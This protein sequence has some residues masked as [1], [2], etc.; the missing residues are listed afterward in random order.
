MMYDAST[1]P[2]DHDLLNQDEYYSMQ[3]KCE[4]VG[5]PSTKLLNCISPMSGMTQK[6]PIFLNN[7][8]NSVGLDQ[9]SP[10]TMHNSIPILS[11]MNIED[12]TED[13]VGE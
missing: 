8:K 5:P 7:K 12:I 10:G 11:P 3:P 9:Q 1:T 13:S 2:L 6:R 4:L